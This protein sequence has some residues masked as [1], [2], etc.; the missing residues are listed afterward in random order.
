MDNIYL[1]HLDWGGRVSSGWPGVGRRVTSVLST[2]TVEGL[3][4]D[5]LGGVY[6]MWTDSRDTPGVNAQA[7]LSHFSADG[8]LVPGWPTEGVKAIPDSIQGLKGLAP[9]DEGGVFVTVVDFRLGGFEGDIYVQHVLADGTIAP[10]WPAL[11]KPVVRCPGQQDF[12]VETQDGRGGLFL[13]WGGSA[14]HMLADGSIA[15]DSCG[16]RFT[17]LG[18]TGALVPSHGGAIAAV[19]K[20]YPPAYLDNDA[21]TVGFDSTGAIRPEWSGGPLPAVVAPSD[22]FNFDYASDGAGGLFVSWDDQRNYAITATDHYVQ[23]I[24]DNGAPAPGWPVNG[25][26]IVASP[27]FDNQVGGGGSIMPDGSGGVYALAERTGN[28][29]PSSGIYAGHVAASGQVAPGWSPAGETLTLPPFG[30]GADGAMLCSDGAGG[31]IAVISDLSILVQHISPDA[32]VPTQVSL[33]RVDARSDGVSLEWYAGGG[34]LAQATVERE[35]AAEGWVELAQVVA[36]G[37][38]TLRYEDRAVVPGERYGYRLAYAANGTV[39]HTAETWV[40][41]P[42]A[43]HFALAGA[44]A[45]P[46]AAGALSLKFS[47]ASW[48]PAELSL[49]DLTGRRVWRREVGVLGA[50]EH[51][52]A[53]GAETAL[54]P[55]LYWA[56]LQQAGQTAGARIALVP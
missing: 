10:G 43:A 51:T 17:T 34:G 45:N 23:H 11:G 33:S 5:A 19:I 26:P 48:A 46:S 16:K 12:F 28:N 30:D 25:V 50:G 29:D 39:A 32:P 55:G 52:L 18:P 41:V 8:S 21:Y 44:V 22:Q 40:T 53:V 4:L 56:R 37:T 15:W 38:G 6:V 7:F 13:A 36:D 49:Y 35:H 9:D 3:A 31:A 1:Q 20:L 2:Q 24:L 47:L 14:Q 42:L 27:I 54:A